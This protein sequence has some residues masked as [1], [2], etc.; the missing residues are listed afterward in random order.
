[1]L[2]G[3]G[4]RNKTVPP[5]ARQAALATSKA[6]TDFYT[7]DFDMMVK[8]SVTKRRRGGTIRQYCVTVNGS[9]K[10]VTSGDTVDRQ[11]YDALLAAGAIVPRNAEPVPGQH[12]PHD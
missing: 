9:T 8:G 11:T 3:K 4:R 2:F 10:L 5:P 6:A 7:I 12:K 1:M